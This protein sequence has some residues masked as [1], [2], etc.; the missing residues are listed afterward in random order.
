MTTS[1]ANIVFFFLFKEESK[2]VSV[3]HW[4]STLFNWLAIEDSENIFVN[5]E[6]FQSILKLVAH[7]SNSNVFLLTLQMEDEKFAWKSWGNE[8]Q[9]RE[10]LDAVFKELYGTRANRVTHTANM[11]TSVLSA[12]KPGNKYVSCLLLRW[13]P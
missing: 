9:F 5:L 1:K 10:N 13:H 4:I 7:T 11:Y 12:R 3:P 6:T 2:E 8:M